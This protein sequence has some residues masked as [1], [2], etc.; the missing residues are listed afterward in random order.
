MSEYLSLEEQHISDLNRG[1]YRAF[2]ALYSMYSHRLYGFVF[3]LTKSQSDANDIVQDV[4]V[5][6]WL[7]RENILLDTSFQAYLFT[8][9]KNMVINKIR[10][11]VNSPI[12]VDYVAYLNDRQLAENNVDEVLNYDDFK[13]RLNLA[14]NSLSQTQR[15]VFELS[16]ELGYNN[17]EI[18]KHLELSEQT[19][20]N[21]LSNALKI[22]RERMASHIFLFNL[23]FM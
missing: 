4:F 5:K 8:I 12:F 22:L 17:A 16:K 18:A 21:Q 9:A 7:N 13:L 14:K 20:K 23:F 1:S 6:L 11:N 19:V 15:N 2:D 10:A 3:K